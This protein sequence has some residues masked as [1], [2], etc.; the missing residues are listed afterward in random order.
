MPILLARRPPHGLN[1]MPALATYLHDRRPDALIASAPNC[2]LAAVWAKRLAG[3]ATRVLITEHTA[4]S[5]AL[6]KTGNWRS[7][8]LPKLMH[9]TY[10]QA[11]S[12]VAVSRALADD[13]AT[14]AH[15]P[16][17]RITTIYNPVVGPHLQRLAAEP[18]DHPWFRPGEPPVILSAGRLSPQKDFPTLVRAFALLRATRRVRLMILGGATSGSKTELRQ[19]DLAAIA[20]GL[21]VDDDVALPGFMPNPYPYMARASVFV[22]ASAWEG[23]GNVLVEAMACGCP[24]VATDCPTGPAE[25]LAG[26]RYG[27]LVPVGDVPSLAAAIGTVLENPPDAAL[28]RGRADDFTVDRSVEAYL[29]ALFGAE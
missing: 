9:R 4:P 8:Y 21:G 16:R 3:V 12:I 6:T 17:Q 7:R 2:N 10:Q 11:D 14:V 5:M 19:S 18:L 24:V 20:A 23:F 26:G 25:I 22:L 15:V 27:P 1:R 29:Q 13:L 28:L